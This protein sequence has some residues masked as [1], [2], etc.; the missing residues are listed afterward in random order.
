M[1]YRIFSIIT[2]LTLFIIVSYVSN[3][4]NFK[5]TSLINSRM[6]SRLPYRLLVL[7]TTMLSSKELVIL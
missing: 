2:V 6:R 7:I 5:F 1:C 4:E 3:N